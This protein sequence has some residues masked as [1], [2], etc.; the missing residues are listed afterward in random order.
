MTYSEI[1]T[2]IHNKEK[3]LMPKNWEKVNSKKPAPFI[4]APSSR[5][6]DFK[7]KDKAKDQPKEAAEDPLEPK[8]SI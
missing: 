2:D 6:M 5:M 8:Y 7:D 4:K 3:I 1:L